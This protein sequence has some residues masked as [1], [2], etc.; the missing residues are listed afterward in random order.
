MFF[1]W[2]FFVFVFAFVLLFIFLK[3]FRFLIIFFILDYHRHQAFVVVVFFCFTYTY[4]TTATSMK[5]WKKSNC[6][7]I[8][9]TFFAAFVGIHIFHLLSFCDWKL[10][11]VYIHSMCFICFVSLFFF[12]F[13]SFVIIFHREKPLNVHTTFNLVVL[14][15]V[16]ANVVLLAI[17]LYI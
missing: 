12:R 2:A 14:V 9:V 17:S 7:E 13:V 6:E 15:V 11:L 4:N 8:I 16:V 1:A 3:H 10:K 5:W